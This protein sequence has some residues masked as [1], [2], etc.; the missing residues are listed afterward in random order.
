MTMD[1][2]RV[3]TLAGARRLY[4]FFLLAGLLCL[5]PGSRAQAA[6]N[7]QQDA[8]SPSAA[9][10]PDKA[11]SELNHHI[12]GLLLIVIGAMV[13]CGQRYRKLAPLQR[14]WP[15]L[16]I[17]AGI[18]LAVWSDAEIW[19]RGNLGWTWLIHHDP[20]ARQHK[21]YA[22]LLIAIGATEYLRARAKLSPRWAPWAFP[23]LAIFGGVF[24][25]FHDHGS[26]EAL[27][28]TPGTHSAAA[29]ASLPDT[30]G[31]PAQQQ[32][33]AGAE[34]HQHGTADHGGTSMP[35]RLVTPAHAASAQPVQHHEHHMTA[36]MLNIK[37]EHMWF[38][39]V[40]FCVALSKFLYDANLLRTRF[41]PYL[42]AHSIILLGILLLLYTE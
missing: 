30:Q 16:F 36:A 11:A 8:I 27:P 35:A 26:V 3:F 28:E 42:W 14:L 34:T 9:V 25:F 29:H 32:S 41:T 4:V 33:A 31:A 17:A 10:D 39:A 5:S 21:I 7:E 13:I 40:G 15:L 22:I 12:A 6:A 23:A 18:F 1:G 20:E 2:S 19:P 38:A 24:L 37:R